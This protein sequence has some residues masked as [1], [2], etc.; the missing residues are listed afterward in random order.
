[1][2]VATTRRQHKGVV[3]ETHLLRR[4]YREDGKVKSQ[5]LANLSYLPAATIQ[6]IKESL[7][8]KSHQILGEDWEIERSLPHG[9]VAAIWAMANKL[10][11]ESLIGP[12]CRERDIVMSLVI[13]RAARPAS[14]LAT[15]R[16]WSDTSLAEDFA[17]DGASTDEVYQAMDWL[18]E[19]Q[20]K[21]ETGLARR[22]LSEG[23]RV[24]YD[25]SSSWMEGNS[26]PLAT[27]GYSRDKK[28]G[29][30]QIEYGLMTDHE[31]RPIS[32]EVFSGNTAD[33]KAFVSAVNISRERFR[34]SELV[35][36]GDR[37]MITQ[38]RIQAL[39]ELGGPGWITC[40]RAPQIRMLMQQGALQLGLFDEVNLATITHPDYPGERLI[41]CRNP[42]LAKVRARTRLEL[43]EA[44]EAE[45]AKI[46][47]S[48]ASKTLLGKDKIA[49]R[50]GRVI[51]RYKVAKHFILAIEDDHFSFNRD[52]K[53]IESEA[54]LDGI[55]V[56]RTS[57]G[58]D[59]MSDTDAVLAYKGL[60]V[61]ERDFRNLKAID[62][63]LRPIYHW[64]EQRVRAHVFL[65]MLS[66]YV[67]WHLRRAWAPLCFSDEEIPKRNDPVAQALR[68]EKAQMKDAT[69]TTED[70]QVVH[71]FQTLLDHLATLTRNKVA[72]AKGVTIDKL[73]LPTPTQRRAFELIGIP[74]PTTL[75][76]RRQKNNADDARIA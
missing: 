38:A 30:T 46:A 23:S 36:V 12:S 40:L 18:V 51:N 73:S 71:S 56:I 50:A 49:L 63:D 5:T 53:A 8:G 39:A 54:A 11:L 1:M 62:L 34:L 28:R 74:I 7:A 16:W 70:G 59:Q 15:T 57:V 52:Q 76:T 14:K 27:Y 72:F 67:T 19:R 31:G 3:Y 32:I 29:K 41:A 26:C 60:S 33:P 45:L 17:V 21:I 25:L 43:L 47:D 9:H 2:H 58:E 6:L 69:K 35:L 37:G 61:V 22:H 66:A 68:S 75:G 42:D 13:S 20:A 64:S 24:L 48:V 10:K 44:T 55:Y 65:C 4:S